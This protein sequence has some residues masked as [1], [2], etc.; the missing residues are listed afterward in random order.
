MFTMNFQNWNIWYI[1]KVIK[2]HKVSEKKEKKSIQLTEIDSKKNLIQLKKIIKFVC[3]HIIYKTIV[4]SIQLIE[5]NLYLFRILVFQRIKTEECKL[6][7]EASLYWKQIH[8]S[9]W[10]LRKMLQT[11]KD[12]G[13]THLVRNFMHLFLF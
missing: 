8:H 5:C 3:F 6:M 12:R 11:S 4:D 7:R 13:L 2:C 9:N 1:Q 10:K